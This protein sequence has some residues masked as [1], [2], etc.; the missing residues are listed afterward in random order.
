MLGEELQQRPPDW[1]KVQGL[2]AVIQAYDTSIIREK[3]EKVVHD[4]HNG[5]S[6]IRTKRW[7]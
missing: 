7:E 6:V 5:Y 1:Q 2:C 3:I 4:L